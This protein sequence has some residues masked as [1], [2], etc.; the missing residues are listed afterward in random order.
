MLS[1]ER[2]S[3]ANKKENFSFRKFGLIIYQKNM[4]ICRL[5]IERNYNG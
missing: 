3:T 4:Y 5:F 1:I 2:K